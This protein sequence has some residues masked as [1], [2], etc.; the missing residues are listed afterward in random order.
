MK[1]R[2]VIFVLILFIA[3]G[4]LIL[5]SCNKNPIAYS[6][7]PNPINFIIPPGFPA[8]TY[9]FQSNP[10]TEEGFLLGR[11]LFYD[12]RL[13]VDGSVSCASCHQSIAAFTT[14]EHDRSHGVNHNHTLRNAPGLFNLA[15]YPHF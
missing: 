7:P 15:W 8:P 2:L 13:S 6:E 3:S 5:E 1:Q 12:T 9:S 14:L 11:K 10:L 4:V